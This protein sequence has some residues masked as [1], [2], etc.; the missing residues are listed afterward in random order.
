M[1]ESEET[2]AMRLTGDHDGERPDGV[3]KRRED[4]TGCVSTKPWFVAAPASSSAL[5]T[6][7]SEM[8]EACGRM[9]RQALEQVAEGGQTDIVFVL[10][11][12]LKVRGHRCWMTARCRY[13]ETM[14]SSGMRESRTGVI[15]VEE[16]SDESFL[17]LHEFLYTGTMSQTTACVADARE[18]WYLSDIWDLPG[19]KALLC[20]CVCTA[21]VEAAVQVAREVGDRDLLQSCADWLCNQRVEDGRVGR[22]V[23]DVICGSGKDPVVLEGGIKWLCLRFTLVTENFESL[24]FHLSDD[25]SIQSALVEFGTFV[26]ESLAR[27][28]DARLDSVGCRALLSLYNQMAYRGMNSG[29]AL[30][31]HP[32]LGGCG[33]VGPVLGAM[34]RMHPRIVQWH[35]DAGQDL[36]ATV[37]A[38]RVLSEVAHDAPHLVFSVEG[39]GVVRAVTRLL[40]A[41]PTHLEAQVNACYALR[42][43]VYCDNPHHMMD[44]ARD[45]APIVAL[46]A[47]EGGIEEMVQ[48][49]GRSISS[50]GSS[51]CECIQHYAC[52]AL[53]YLADQGGADVRERV[54]AATGCGGVV[55]RAMNCFSRSSTVQESGCR[56]LYAMLADE[57]D[58]DGGLASPQ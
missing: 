53:G 39:G 25:M 42:N 18:L 37:D 50:V 4:E 1:E 40:R 23:L 26:A 35:E 54:L 41:L 28:G 7:S 57:Q 11:S 56:A 36:A 15:K 31:R 48:A 17:A 52:A 46:I 33:V 47:E 43:L 32:S 22:T 9:L 55:V 29:E 58:G 6:D 34:G 49:M 10:D 20:R 14:L 30:C 3:E 38:S 51:E 27:I 45:F 8:L 12:G 13:L 16:C 24:E 21:N 44:S 5:T 2:P 19:L